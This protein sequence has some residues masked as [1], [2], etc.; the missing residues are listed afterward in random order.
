MNYK[1]ISKITI[2]SILMGIFAIIGIICFS[3][4]LPTFQKYGFD[5]L[6]DEEVFNYKNLIPIY[7]EQV[8]AWS[9]ASSVL[10][11]LLTSLIIWEIKKMENA[12]YKKYFIA[13][14]GVFTWLIIPY[15]AYIGIKDKL[16]SKFFEYISENKPEHLQIS[17]SVVKNGIIGKGKKD[18][19]FWNTILGSFI[20][21]VTLV[22]LFFCFLLAENL[23]GVSVIHKINPNNLNNGWGEVGATGADKLKN[24]YSYLETTYMFTTFI[25]FT[26][27][28]NISCFV[29]MFSFLLFSKKN[30]FKN[31]TIMILVSSYIFIVSA[32]FWA[33]LFPQSLKNN[34]YV[35]DFQ[36]AKT[37]W[38]HAVTP[39]LFIIFSITSIFT[40]KQAP[41]KL[42][43]TVGV[44]V[45]YPAFYGL[46]IYPLTFITRFSVYG[47]LTN[48][49]PNMSP[50]IGILQNGKPLISN[51]NPLMVLGIFGL[52]ILFIL[53]ISAFW[54]IAYFVNKKEVKRIGII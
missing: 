31:N 19:V 30:A 35:E 36:W 41:N 14:L 4:S 26:Q 5:S 11:I 3:I 48:M 40:N 38:L 20:F 37:I 6:K 33:Y 45:I 22:G 18:K 54:S 39:I 8:R 53:V 43:T 23:Y 12:N 32:I 47:G 49:N 2:Y 15:I 50:I 52:L 16:Y 1:Q 34:K 28:T 46:F 51:G 25:F 13:S 21:L 24:Y 27:L 44:G 42:K 7:V 29:F 17:F 9:L 10:C